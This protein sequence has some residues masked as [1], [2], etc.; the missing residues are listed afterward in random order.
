MAAYDIMNI[1]LSQWNLYVS[2]FKIEMN[3][4]VQSVDVAFVSTMPSFNGYDEFISDIALM[5]KIKSQRAID[6][7][8]KEAWEQLLTVLAL[9]G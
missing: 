8:V 9:K 7:A 3:D 6:P 4:G 2:S 1:D 5:S